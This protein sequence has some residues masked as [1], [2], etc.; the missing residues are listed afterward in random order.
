MRKGEDRG[1]WVIGMKLIFVALR[2]LSDSYSVPGVRH[3]VVKSGII[4]QIYIHAV[5][6]VRHQVGFSRSWG[7]V[8]LPKSSRRFF[9]GK[10]NV[11]A[12]SRRSYARLLFVGT[13]S[14]ALSSDQRGEIERRMHMQ[15]RPTHQADAKA[16]PA[17]H[18]VNFR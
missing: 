12:L 11:P 8:F 1:E 17:Y 14:N 15:H 6:R 3:Q 13:Y 7:N 5:P 4:E 2:R 16:Y 9:L 10:G 18:S